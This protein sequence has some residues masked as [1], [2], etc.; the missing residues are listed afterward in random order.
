MDLGADDLLR[1]LRSLFN[2]EGPEMIG[3]KLDRALFGSDLA[4]NIEEHTA[5]DGR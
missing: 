2:D 4:D 3:I 5:D 1:D